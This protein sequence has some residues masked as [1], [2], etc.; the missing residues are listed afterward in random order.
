MAAT[1]RLHRRIRLTRRSGSGVRARRLPAAT[2]ALVAFTCPLL[3]LWTIGVVP[4]SPPPS[5]GMELHPG[6]QIYFGQ[7]VTPTATT[8][9]GPS[10]TPTSTAPVT[11]PTIQLV[12]P[13]SGQGPVGA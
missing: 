10:P 8:A 6:P 9:E 13:S 2:L 3:L 4:P 7:K 11:P 5:H 12:S 1:E